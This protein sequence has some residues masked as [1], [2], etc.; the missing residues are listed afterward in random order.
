MKPNYSSPRPSIYSQC[1]KCVVYYTN[2]ES[3]RRYISKSNPE[4]AEE[5][6]GLVIRRLEDWNVVTFEGSGSC[7]G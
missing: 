1:I 2:I 3:N 4:E 6:G 5:A 7:P